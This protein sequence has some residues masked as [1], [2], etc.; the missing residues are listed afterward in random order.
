MNNEKQ[1]Y[2]IAKDLCQTGFCDLEEWNGC[3]LEVGEYCARCTS[4][5]KKLHSFFGYRKPVEGR[6]EK[7]VF[8]I[9]DSEKVGYKCSE[10]NTT[11]DVATPHCPNC[12]ARMKGEGTNG[13][14]SR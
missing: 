5:A 2:E 11:W 3:S 12:G 14:N 13:S 8:V 9:F 4:C 7:R 6:W 1:I 10:C